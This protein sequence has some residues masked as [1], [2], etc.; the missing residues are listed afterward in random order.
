MIYMQ[1]K[2]GTRIVILEPDNLKTIREGGMV[3]SPD[4]KHE[5]LIVF[6]PDIVWTGQQIRAILDRG[7]DSLDPDKLQQILD[8][9]LHRAEVY[10]RPYH[11]REMIS[12]RRE[13]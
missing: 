8:E 11:H 10:E 2:D 1:G 3:K 7:D 5:T 9:G 6:A 12:G 13:R 4:D